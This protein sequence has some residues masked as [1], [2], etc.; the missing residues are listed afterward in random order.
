MVYAS[1]SLK[2]IFRISQL[3]QSFNFNV[4]LTNGS[5]C[6][7]FFDRLSRLHLYLQKTPACCRCTKPSLRMVLWPCWG[8]EMGGGS[9]TVDHCGR[10]DVGEAAHK[11]TTQV[12]VPSSIV[13]VLDHVQICKIPSEIQE[14]TKCFPVT[15]ILCALKVWHACFICQLI[16]CF[17]FHKC[18]GCFRQAL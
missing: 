17:L 16:Y 6:D 11:E 10:A 15:I 1:Q 4:F 3:L 8:V 5:H 12:S 2:C 13:Y 9:L 7:H 18:L 14:C